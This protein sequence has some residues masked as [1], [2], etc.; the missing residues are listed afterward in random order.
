MRNLRPRRQFLGLTMIELMIT[1]TIGAILLALA[2]PSMREYI[3]RKRVSG[4]AT[5]LA[6][7]IRLA[8]SMVQQENQPIW[9]NFGSTSDYTCYVVFTQGNGVDYCECNRTST[10]MCSAVGASPPIALRSVFIKKSSGIT[11]IP[12]TTELLYS[13]ALGAPEL[14]FGG[15]ANA[16]IDGGTLGGRV[17][18]NM[19]G[20]TKATICS[21]SGHTAEFGNCS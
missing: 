14:K 11:I 1:L 16:E 15:A 13:Q 3:A 2:V 18:V 7:D 12:K 9:I 19:S 6:A 10:P 21:V 8:R 20:L 17:K 4:T 5:E